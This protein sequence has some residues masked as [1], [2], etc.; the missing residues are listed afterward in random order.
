MIPK[1][2]KRFSDKIM[3]EQ[4]QVMRKTIDAAQSAASAI[5]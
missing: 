3:R 5:N 4:D 1:S 2:V